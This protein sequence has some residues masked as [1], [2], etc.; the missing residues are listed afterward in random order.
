VIGE[1]VKKMIKVGLRKTPH[2]CFL[3][4]LPEE[5]NQEATEH[6]QMGK[7]SNLEEDGPWQ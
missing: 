4:D 1:S 3:K 2:G 6:A 7:S 5:Y